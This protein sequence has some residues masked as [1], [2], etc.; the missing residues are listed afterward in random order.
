MTTYNRKN[1]SFKD[2]WVMPVEDLDG[3]RKD[4]NGNLITNGMYVKRFYN[5]LKELVTKKGYRINNENEL[6]SEIVTMIYNSSRDHYG[7]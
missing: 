1:H 5:N 2:W 7:Y 3:C 4:N 6:K